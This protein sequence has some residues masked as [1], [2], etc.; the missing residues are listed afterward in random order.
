MSDDRPTYFVRLVSADGLTKI[1][2][3]GLNHPGHFVKTPLYYP[4]R[5]LDGSTPTADVVMPER[6]YVFAGQ[7]QIDA[8][9]IEVE[10]REVKP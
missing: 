3:H 9:R 4:T 6:E 5:T 8:H 7:T 1:W 2:R 10:Y